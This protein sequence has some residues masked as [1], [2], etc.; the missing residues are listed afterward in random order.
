MKHA[1]R[2]QRIRLLF[3][4]YIEM[5]AARDERLTK[6]FSDNFC[7]YTGSGAFLAKDH[8]QW[9]NI[10]RLDFSQVNERIHIEML[11][12]SLQDL[13]E[14]VVLATALFHIHLPKPEPMLSRETARLTLVFRREGEDWKIVHSGISIPFVAAEEGEVYPLKAMKSQ[15]SELL[16][17]VAERTRD[18]EEANRKLELLNNTDGLTGVA[19]RRMFD[20]ALAQ[21]WSRGHRNAS[22]LSVVMLDVDHFKRFNDHY[23]HLAGDDCLRALAQALL[24]AG[25]RAGEL[26]ARFGGEEFVVLMP[27]TNLSSA[28]ESAQRMQQQVWDLAVPHVKS[29]HAIVTFSFGV[30]CLTPSQKLGPDVLLREADAALYRAKKSKRNCIK[31]APWKLSLNT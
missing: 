16:A 23:G 5:Y 8:E 26:V 12:L 2:H 30:S 14:D 15:N 24:R 9:V 20:Q 29:Q 19:S 31:A 21:E 3:D 17:L 13:T 25:R 1:K 4:D 22:N 18:L 10:T 6:C 7:G 11:D 28:M 27:D